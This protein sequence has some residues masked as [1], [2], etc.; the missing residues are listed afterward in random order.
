MFAIVVFLMSGAMLF[1]MTE[2]SF[3][4]LDRL[5]NV[6]MPNKKKGYLIFSYSK[7]DVCNMLFRNMHGLGEDFKRFAKKIEKKKGF[8]EEKHRVLSLSSEQLQQKK[9]NIETAKK[10]LRVLKSMYAHNKIIQNFKTGIRAYNNIF[11]SVANETKKISK[12]SKNKSA[13]KNSAH[14]QVAPIPLTLASTQVFQRTKEGFFS[15]CFDVFGC[16]YKPLV[17]RLL[18]NCYGSKD[19]HFE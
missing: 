14:K 2:E 1:G 9:S 16:C 5:K 3:Q 13:S 15:K 12:K 8:D 10:L 4:L 11:T 6:K 7:N 19:S 17:R 18:R